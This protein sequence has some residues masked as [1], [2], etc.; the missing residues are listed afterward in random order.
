MADVIAFVIRKW[1]ESSAG[2]RTVGH[3]T[4]TPP[5]KRCHDMVWDRVKFKRLSFRKLNVPG[6]LTDYLKDVRRLA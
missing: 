4:L 3:P 5:F 1:A 6:I 2:L